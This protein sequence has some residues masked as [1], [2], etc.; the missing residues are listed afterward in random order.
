MFF[1]VFLASIKIFH[2]GATD[3]LKRGAIMAKAPFTNCM[4]AALV[5]DHLTSKSARTH[6]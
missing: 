1:S 2:P 4:V 6:L 3:L 5:F